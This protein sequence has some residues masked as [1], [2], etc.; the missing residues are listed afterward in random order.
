MDRIYRKLKNICCNM[1]SFEV[2]MQ[3]IQDQIDESMKLT[4]PGLLLTNAKELEN[5]LLTMLDTLR[6]RENTLQKCLE[7][8][9]QSLKKRL[10]QQDNWVN[11]KQKAIQKMDKERHIKFMGSLSCCEIMEKDS[12]V[13]QLLNK[14]R[15]VVKENDKKVKEDITRLKGDLEEL[16]TVER[17]Y[18]KGW[19][20]KLK[21]YLEVVSKH[22]MQEKDRRKE[23]RSKGSYLPVHS[24]AKDSLESGEQSRND[25][26]SYLTYDKNYEDFASQLSKLVCI[27]MIFLVMGTVCFEHWVINWKDIRGTILSIDV[28]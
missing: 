6:D 9:S 28:M 22:Q 8:E 27:F 11:T 12:E 14:V 19:Q 5:N 10:K 15:K 16:D 21:N 17:K 7:I 4:R 25:M 26:D 20:K 3:Q 18:I 13:T 2:E 23:N 24:N 1:A